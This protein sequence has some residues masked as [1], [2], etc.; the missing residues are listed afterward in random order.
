MC[1]PTAVHASD[2]VT[3]LVR[4]FRYCLHLMLPLP[5]PAPA[6]LHRVAAQGAL[7]ADV[8]IV[9]SALVATYT[10]VPALEGSGLRMAGPSSGSREDG[11]SWAAAVAY[12][13]RRAARIV[14]AYTVA[15]LIALAVFGL[16]Q[17]RS[18]EH[19]GPE[20]QAAALLYRGCPAGL[21]HNLAF[22][23][24]SLPLSGACG[25]VHG[26]RGWMTVGCW[27]CISKRRQLVSQ[28]RASGSPAQSNFLCPCQRRS[29]ETPLPLQT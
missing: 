2:H 23:S 10:L 28:A 22:L 27:K 14:P 25:C 12:W 11:S 3:V 17:R 16:D 6:L 1:H 26:P 5:G 24:N 9:L 8:L 21:W 20:A 7:G 29:P 15:N 18:K 4:L 19:L 13:R